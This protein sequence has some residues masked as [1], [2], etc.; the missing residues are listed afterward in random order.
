LKRIEKIKAWIYEKLN[1]TRPRMGDISVSVYDY[2]DKK[3]SEIIFPMKYHK[4]NQNKIL[5]LYITQI[6]EYY[7]INRNNIIQVRYGDL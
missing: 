1:N 7:E 6:K 5:Y 3:P 2:N 4:I